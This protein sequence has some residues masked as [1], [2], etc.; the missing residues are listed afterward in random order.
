MEY[1]DTSR[2]FMEHGEREVF[3][4]E[5]EIPMRYGGD[6]VGHATVTREGLYH[7]V[8]C[9]CE[10]VSPEVLRAYGTVDGQDVLL[11][12]LMPEGGQLTLD[13]RFACS[14]CPLDRLETVTV[15]GPPG[16]WQPW[17]GAIGPV[18]V[19]GGRARQSNGKLLLALPYHQ[20]EPV[21]YLPVLRYCTPPELEGRT[22]MVLDTDQLPEEWRPRS[23]ES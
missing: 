9:V 4:M 2:I 17:Q 12:V 19:A 23:E 13:R 6:T 21:D 20:G 15:G 8:R 16:A 14:A 1:P 7:R 22:W 3:C 5:R 18:T 11:G 10:A